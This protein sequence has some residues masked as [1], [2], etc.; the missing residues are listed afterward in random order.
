MVFIWFGETLEELVA[1]LRQPV[2]GEISRAPMSALKI[3]KCQT[4]G[5][6]LTRA[7][8]TPNRRHFSAFSKV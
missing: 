7:F 3:E 8:L 2:T 4:E 1:Q 6:F 5:L